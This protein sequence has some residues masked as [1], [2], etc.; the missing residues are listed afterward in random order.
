MM[1]D[2][3]KPTIAGYTDREGLETFMRS[4]GAEQGRGPRPDPHKHKL[5]II[6]S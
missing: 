1:W 2:H 6:N 4:N 5:L 3:V